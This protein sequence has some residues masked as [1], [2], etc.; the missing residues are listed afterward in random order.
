MTDSSSKLKIS[1]YIRDR[2]KRNFG[3]CRKCEK[4]VFFFLNISITKQY[5]PFSFRREEGLLVDL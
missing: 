3:T 2:D 1:D 5:F 4:I